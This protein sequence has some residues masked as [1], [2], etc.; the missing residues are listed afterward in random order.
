VAAKASPRRVC[1]EDYTSL[2]TFGKDLATCSIQTR[3][4]R[5]KR[6]L[7]RYCRRLDAR[8]VILF[9]DETDLRFFPLLGAAWALRGK[10]AKVRITGYNARRVISGVI[11]VRTG[12]RLWLVQARQRSMEFQEVL[13]TIHHHYCGW[14]VVLFLDEDSSHTAQASQ[15][16][17]ADLGITLCWLPVRCP[18][19]NPMES[20]WRH[21][22][23]KRCVNRQ[24]SSIDEQTEYFLKELKTMSPH[25][26]LSTS[27]VLSGNFWLLT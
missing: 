5:K 9:E 1:D 16:C 18:E 13:H 15:A 22:K 6:A 17:A 24:Y 8:T 3:S 27:G 23:A 19:L 4:E 25:Q 26:A 21:A 12:H 14:R 20:L 2:D 10:R 7:R 11:N